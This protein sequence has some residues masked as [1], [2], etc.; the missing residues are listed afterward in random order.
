MTLTR[1]TDTTLTHAGRKPRANHGIVNPPVYHASTI[2]FPT[3]AALEDVGKPFETYRYG[4]QGTPTSE[5]FEEA[6]SA[7]EGGYRA[8]AV[9]SGLAAITGALTAFLKAGDHLLMVDSVYGP[10]R[11]FCDKVLKRFGV[12]T[13]YYDPLIGGEIAELIREETRVVFMES[14]GSHTF[15]VQDVPAIV[16]A[17]R[18]RGAVTMI[19]NTWATPLFFRPFDHGVDLSLH[20]ATK[21]MVGHS[22]AMMGVIAARTE[23]H[24]LTAK[25]GTYQLGHCAGPDDL[26]LAQRGLRTMAVRLRHHQDAALKV[27]EWLRGRPEVSRVLHPALPDDPGHAL[28]KRDFTG[29]SGLFGLVLNPAPKPAV[30]ALLDGM[31]LFAMGYSWGG[32]ESLIIPTHPENIR[33]ATTWN[34]EGPTLRLHIGL[35]DVDDLIDD[36]ARGFERLNRAQ[37]A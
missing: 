11:I 18:A 6:V 23:E 1:K 30:N 24:F 33:T 8:I 26:Y 34:A 10:T 32:Y 16:K 13:T 4:R 28:W 31:D 35:E 17:A 22:D 21:Y 7:M 19:D 25:T 20:A 36:L 5:A 2:L 14:P 15:E 12:E 29:A 3:V 9:E 27:A 37:A